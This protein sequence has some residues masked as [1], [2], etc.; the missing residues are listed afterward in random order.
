MWAF[1]IIIISSSS[2]SC[3]I[4]TKKRICHLVGF[5]EPE[6]HK[7]KGEKLDR[8]LN[9]ELELKRLCLLIFRS[10]ILFTMIKIV[11]SKN[12]YSFS[13]LCVYHTRLN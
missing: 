6:D 8:Y 9:F 7:V 12:N 5:T 4:H 3:S 13:S 10:L 11:F 2:S 1:I